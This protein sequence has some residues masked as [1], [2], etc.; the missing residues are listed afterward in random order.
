MNSLIISSTI[1]AFVV[2]I[3]LCVQLISSKA[4]Q[5][6]G[7]WIL[8]TILDAIAA[9]TLIVQ[10]GNYLLP[11]AYTIGSTVVVIC[12]IKSKNFETWTLFESFITLLVIVCIVV[13]ASSGAKVATIASS[14]ALVIAGA[15][16]LRESYRRPWDTPIL[17]YAG[18]FLANSLATLGGKNWSIEERFYP[19][20]AGI[21]CLLVAI[22]AVRKLWIKQPIAPP[23][24]AQATT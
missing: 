17:I 13:W 23:T 2:Y 8:W 24:T 6:L 22:V 7:T 4:K 18:Y 11:V 9:G 21:Y 15:P 1:V 20:C 10:H 16:Q 14:L 5:N 19:A 12:I 3:L